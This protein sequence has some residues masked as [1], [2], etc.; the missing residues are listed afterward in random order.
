[1]VQLQAQANEM[2]YKACQLEE[3]E[4]KLCEVKINHNR[5]EGSEICHALDNPKI[6]LRSANFINGELDGEFICR[7]FTNILTIRAQYRAGQLDGEYR[8]FSTARSWHNIKTAWWIKYFSLGK[9]IGVEFL[10][11]EN[12]K[13]LEVIPGC[14]ENGDRD[15]IY[16]SACLNMKY[17]EFD[18][19]VR[20]F[21]DG[22]IKKHFAEMNRPVVTKYQDGK[23]KFKATLVNGKYVGAYEKFFEDGKIQLKAN[24]KNGFPES[25]EEFFESGA[26]KS[27]R[28]FSNEKLSERL[29]YFENGKISEVVKITYDQFSRTEVAR[30]FSDQGKPYSEH[31]MKFEHG[32]YWGKYVGA[33]KVYDQ[34]GKLIIENNYKNGLRDGP[35]TYYDIDQKTVTI[36]EKG[37]PKTKSIYDAQSGK[38]IEKIEYMNDGSEKARTKT[39][40]ET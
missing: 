12:G 37:K 13:V 38:E 8:D 7:S 2:G 34:D 20:S 29:D 10:A 22:E 1:M 36:W 17:S 24:Y 30:S 28:T 32:E 16:Y 39:V 25:E 18:K 15:S 3:A 35:S 21:I 11:N 6:V 40:D 5:K 4:E 27:K 14:W 26:K 31:T 9:Q 19:E 33:Y 23:V